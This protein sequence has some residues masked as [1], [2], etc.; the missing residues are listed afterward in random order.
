[1]VIVRIA[2]GGY[3]Q[4]QQVMA[5]NYI[6]ALGGQFD[7]LINIDG[8][9]EVALPNSENLSQG[10]YPFFPSL[11]GRLAQDFPNLELQPL[12]G[13]VAYLKDMRKKWA[14]VFVASP[15]HYSIALQ[16][17]WKVWDHFLSNT[18]TKM[19]Y[20][21]QTYKPKSQLFQATGPGVNEFNEE[22]LYK[23]LA[24]LWQRSSIQMGLIC[25]ANNIQY[26]H[27]LQPNQYVEGTKPMGDEERRIALAK[28]HPYKTAVEKGYP[29]LASMASGLRAA[30]VNFY[31]LQML[32]SEVKEPLY[33]D[34]C[35]HFNRVGNII[36]ARRIAQEIIRTYDLG[37]SKH[38]RE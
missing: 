15:M 26:F 13:K 28:A 31:D 12:V 32:F 18:I 5:L 30:G 20:A 34:T 33:I 19:S 17:L 9:N 38:P 25:K 29:Q 16:L 3:K 24:A 6:L 4:P 37:F 14:Q 35:C 21:I 1:M 8:F 36:L 7:I 2:L 10:V 11:W 22:H 23:E 27:F